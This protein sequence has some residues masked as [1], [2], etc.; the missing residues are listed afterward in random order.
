MVS[1]YSCLLHFKSR[2]IFCA[3]SECHFLFLFHCCCLQI[4]Y[5]QLKVCNTEMF[6]F[7]LKIVQ[8][9]TVVV[10]CIRYSILVFSII[11]MLLEYIHMCF[12]ST[13]PYLYSLDK[14]SRGM[15]R[16]M[17]NHRS[18]EALFNRVTY[19]NIRVAY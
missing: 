16:G 6:I 10:Y 19:Y 5:S 1:S 3:K 11:S 14:Y 18:T 4:F 2:C 15:I 17:C 8:S 12:C 9:M 13:F 7:Y